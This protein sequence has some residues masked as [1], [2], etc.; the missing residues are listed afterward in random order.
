M[1][2]IEGLPKVGGKPGAVPPTHD[3]RILPEPERAPKAQQRRG[4]WRVIIQWRGL[5]AKE[6]T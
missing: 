3:G 4:V 2:F 1:D 5:P 6:A